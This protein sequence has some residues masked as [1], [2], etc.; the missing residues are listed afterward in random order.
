M[1]KIKVAFLILALVFS[2]IIYFENQSTIVYACGECCDDGFGGCYDCDPCPPPECDPVL[3]CNC[4]GSCE[5]PPCTDCPCDPNAC[6]EVEPEACQTNPTCGDG[7]CDSGEDC[8]GCP[9]DCGACYDPCEDPDPPEYCNPPECGDG[10]CNGDENCQ[11]CW[12]D[13]GNCCGNG[14]CDVDLGEDQSNCNQDCTCEV[15]EYNE[16]ISCGKSRRISVNEQCIYTVIV[17]SQDD[18]ACGTNCGSSSGGGSSGGGSSSGGGQQQ[19]NVVGKVVQ[20]ADETKRFQKAGQNCP[21]VTGIT[22]IDSN[23]VKVTS[24]GTEAQWACNNDPYYKIS[25]N[26]GSNT[27]TLTPPEGYECDWWNSAVWKMVGGTLVPQDSTS[28]TGCGATV[29]VVNG[30]DRHLWYRVKPQ[31]P[32][33]DGDGH[34]DSACGGDDCNDGNSEIYPGSTNPY[35]NCNEADGKVPGSEICDGS[36]NDCDGISDNGF[37]QDEDDFTTCNGDCNDNQNAGG[38]TIY[39]GA[40]EKCDGIDHNCDGVPYQGVDPDGCRGACEQTAEKG[41]IAEGFYQYTGTD[42]NQYVEQSLEP[43]DGQRSWGRKC[44]ID[45][46]KPFG[47]DYNS[48]SEW[49]NVDLTGGPDNPSTSTYGA[50]CSHEFPS[51]NGKNYLAQALIGKDGRRSWNRICPIESTGGVPATFSWNTPTS[52]QTATSYT[53]KVNKEKDVWAAESCNSP[54]ALCAGEG[55][56]GDFSANMTATSQQA[57]IVPSAKYDWSIQAVPAGNPPDEWKRRS[58]GGSFSCSESGALNQIT[59]INTSYGD[60]GPRSLNLQCTPKNSTMVFAAFSWSAPL[61]TTNFPTATDYILRVNKQQ[62]I[63]SPQPCNNEN[64]LCGDSSTGDF[65][66]TPVSTIF[67]SYISPDSTYNWSIQANPSTGNL[68]TTNGGRFSC[69]DSG[70]KLQYSNP[71]SGGGDSPAGPDV[72][73]GNVP[74]DGVNWA[75]CNDWQ[76]YDLA[77]DNIDP[78]PN[79]MGCDQYTYSDPT[80]KRYLVRS[81]IHSDGQRAYIQKCPMDPTKDR[82]VDW[83]NCNWPM[84]T[85]DLTSDSPDPYDPRFTSLASYIFEGEDGNSYLVRKMRHADGIRSWYRKC[86]LKTD[87]D[88]GVDY[89]TC[90]SWI[91][92]NLPEEKGDPSSSNAQIDIRAKGQNGNG[93]PVMQ[94]WVKDSDWRKINEWTVD[95]SLYKTY[96]TSFSSYTPGQQ[97]AVVF[98]NDAYVLGEYDR[99]LVV[100]Y[101]VVNKTTIQAEDTSRTIYDKGSGSAA[102]DGI[103]IVTAERQKVDNAEVIVWNGALIFNTMMSGQSWTWITGKNKCCGNQPDENVKYDP[104]T[105]SIGCCKITECYD[106]ENE[107]AASGTISGNKYCENGN[108]INRKSLGYLALSDYST[109]NSIPNASIFC[110]SYEDALNQ[111]NYPILSDLAKKYLE[112]D[113][114]NGNGPCAGDFCALES[115]GRAII[116]G[117]ISP[118]PTQS[119]LRAIMNYGSN[120][121]ALDSNDNMI[122]PCNQDP[123]ELWYDSRTNV[124]IYST[125]AISINQNKWQTY[126]QILRTE[127][128]LSIMSSSYS[129]SKTYQKTILGNISSKCSEKDKMTISYETDTNICDATSSLTGGS[130]SGQYYVSSE[131]NSADNKYFQFWTALTSKLRV[132]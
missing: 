94:L 7:S 89:G 131:K 35:C 73:C 65:I 55:G 108:W 16:C 100:D 121:Q 10:A 19:G 43:S 79:F 127:D 15:R 78:N 118:K 6:C 102:F 39:P 31:C 64:M 53:L 88:Y 11:S 25:K 28:G 30:D 26:T 123:D 101:I 67:R 62:D 5:P 96:I 116:S 107:C 81:L 66:A 106:S 14:A 104:N 13:C 24:G 45:P 114:V 56:S 4:D 68:R 59:P 72:S 119:Q 83:E 50:Y 103:D 84:L 111:F 105:C 110:G 1:N 124:F 71:D 49:L 91:P 70:A 120:C 60:G 129:A 47:L 41:Y 51:S 77:N 37:D 132:R 27:F 17:P 33:N 9:D 36:D 90:T 34:K 75:G 2:A 125:E 20:T 32:D 82:G 57:A 46:N 128:S 44:L 122:K 38:S 95:T 3:D 93:W 86:M 22:Y 18:P 112:E 97:I 115:N 52:G 74:D 12:S 61:P 23:A 40:P 98:P 99:N 63:W 130:C 76:F 117:S 126:I 113:C 80:G 87:A 42:G 21:P 69:S 109:S 48:C 8:N 92:E 29:N 54:N 85:I 58:Y